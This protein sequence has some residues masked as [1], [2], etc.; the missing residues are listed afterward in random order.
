MM[1]YIQHIL[2]PYINEERKNLKLSNDHPAL[3]IYNNFKGQCTPDILTFL[4]QKNINVIL[5]PPNC[6]DHL[7][8]LGHSVNKAVKDQL[9]CQFQACYAQE[10][11][12]QF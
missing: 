9:R 8:L 4:D 7:Q 1:E 5:I 6:T 12:H 11:C 10:V 3:V 2:L